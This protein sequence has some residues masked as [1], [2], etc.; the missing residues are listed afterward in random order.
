MTKHGDL[1]RR[2]MKIIGQFYACKERDPKNE[3]IEFSI[4]LQPF[5]SD[6]C[7][8]AIEKFK[9]MDSIRL[10]CILHTTP[11][12]QETLKKLT[13]AEMQATMEQFNNL[14]HRQ[15]KTDYIF[16]KNYTSIQ[17]MKWF[18]IQNLSY[19]SL[20]DS[21]FVNTILAK[22]AV[23]FLIIMDK[24]MQTAEIDP[25]NTMYR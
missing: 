14:Y 6:F 21:I 24:G 19:Q 16:S 11:K 25:N 10:V 20:L 12:I 7:S 23:E 22:E 18:F 13:T 17:N 1:Q 15:Y 8:I 5:K 4:I 9:K 3:N 2:I